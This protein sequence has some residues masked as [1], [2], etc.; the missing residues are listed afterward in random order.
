MEIASITLIEER[1][2][3]WIALSEFYLDTELDDND[4]ERIARIFALSPY[5]ID[6]IKLIDRFEVA[7]VLSIN[8]MSV[9]G[10]WD[11]FDEAWLIESI[12]PHLREK[13]K[14]NLISNTLH[15]YWPGRC[16]KRIY[17]LNELGQLNP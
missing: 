1:K 14:G 16:W 9:A 10:V 17:K 5:S 2:P 3:V 15:K 7:P 8:L 11:A 4:C 12:K 13:H 6:E